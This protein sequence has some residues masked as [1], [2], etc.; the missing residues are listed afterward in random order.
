MRIMIFDEDWNSAAKTR[1][2]L[3]SLEGSPQICWV[4]SVAEALETLIKSSHQPVSAILFEISLEGQDWD[5]FYSV[6]QPLGLLENI[7]VI[8]TSNDHEDV[9]RA[10]AL[11]MDAHGYLAKPLDKRR[12]EEMLSRDRLFWEL[13]ELPRDLAE[14]WRIRRLGQTKANKFKSDKRVLAL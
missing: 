7:A 8:A 12:L 2:A 14:Y 5:I 10:K 13:S 3:A 1:K 4:R 11:A 9:V 6:A